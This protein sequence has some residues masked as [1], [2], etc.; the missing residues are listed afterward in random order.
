MPELPE[1]ETVRIKLHPYLINQ[2]IKKVWYDRPHMLLPDAPSFIKKVEGSKIIDTSRRG[3]YLFLHLDNNTF[4]ECHLKMSG[5]LLIRSK[6]S[7]DEYVHVKLVLSNSTQLYFSDPRT[8]GYLKLITLKELKTR[9]KSLGPEPLDDLTLE[10]LY[11]I[12]QSTTTKIKE[13][14]LDQSLIAGIGNI[15][16][17]DALWMAKIHPEIPANLISYKESSV[18]H[19]AIISVLEESLKLGGSSATWYIHPDGEKGSYQKY[20]KVYK[21]TDLPCP[22]HPDKPIEYLKVG[23]RGTY[24]CPECQQTQDLT[25]SF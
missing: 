9:L 24:I 6:V 4:I 13:V 3:K 7:M 12:F 8:F 22:R 18:L 21:Q 2:T 10:K 1:V 16:A 11:E 5:R 15:Y 25:L 23:G 19:K 17:N 20:F 14:L